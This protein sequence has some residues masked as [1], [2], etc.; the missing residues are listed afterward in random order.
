MKIYNERPRRIFRLL[1]LVLSIQLFVWMIGRDSLELDWWRTLPF[2]FPLLYG[3]PIAT[4]TGFTLLAVALYFA[5]SGAVV[6]SLAGFFYEADRRQRIAMVVVL[7][8]VG[9]AALPLGFYL[10]RLIF[11]Y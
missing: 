3:L 10:R 7:P 9:M 6:W 1:F 8:L 4:A 5:I 11:K 2:A